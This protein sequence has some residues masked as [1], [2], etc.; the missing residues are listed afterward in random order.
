MS[1][2][3]SKILSAALGAVMG[4]VITWAAIR[5]TDRALQTRNEEQ[6]QGN[7]TS[8]RIAASA[9]R[10]ANEI[11]KSQ[12]RVEQLSGAHSASGEGGTHHE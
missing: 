5:S 1:A 4:F 9:C 12:E 10:R 11:I 2:H 6:C 7:L 8:L 3:R